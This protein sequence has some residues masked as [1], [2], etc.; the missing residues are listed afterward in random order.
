MTKNVRWEEPS[1][2][3]R[4]ERC[5]NAVKVARERDALMSE[6]KKNPS[7]WARVDDFA[8]RPTAKTVKRRLAA[9]YPEHEFR[10]ET[11]EGRAVIFACFPGLRDEQAV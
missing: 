7:R 2:A 9:R 10:C 11:K 8:S 3:N 4:H 1:D 6:L 5:I